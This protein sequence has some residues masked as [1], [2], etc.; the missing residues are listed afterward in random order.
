MIQKELAELRERRGALGDKAERLNRRCLVE[1]RDFF[2]DE[3]KTYDGLVAQMDGLAAEI[4]VVE[5]RD[6]GRSKLPPGILEDVSPSTGFAV[7][8][9]RPAELGPEQRMADNIALDESKFSREEMSEFSLGRAVRGMATG[10]WDGAEVEHRVVQ[11]SSNTAGGF[12]TPEIL[13]SQF[14]DRIRNQARVL[15]AGATVVPVLS[16][17]HSIPRMTAGVSGTWRAE[18]AAVTEETPAFDRITF[19]VKSLATLVKIS[20]ELLQD[21]IP[22]SLDGVTHD[23]LASLALSLDEAALRGTGSSNQPLGLRNQSGVTV[24]SM[25]TNGAAPTNWT[26]LVNAV[27]TVQQNNIEPNAAIWSARTAK[28]FSLL[29]DTTGQ[30]LEPPNLL[31]GITNYVTNQIPNNLTQG[32]ASTASE[33]YVGNFADLL[34]GVRPSISVQIQRLNERYADN[35]QVGIL[36]YLRADV[37]VRHPES[38]AVVSGVL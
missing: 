33:I 16:D 4:D 32:S 15:Q 19:Q 25:G 5:R 11:E 22:S 21:A 9:R 29:A 30:P 26:P 31:D 1:K 17:Q 18:N 36:A 3:R 23:I 7:A 12:L 20:Y 8:R 34:I 27:S 10:A 2:P 28:E 13:G 35:M 14:V 24:I 6:D 38:F 37:Q